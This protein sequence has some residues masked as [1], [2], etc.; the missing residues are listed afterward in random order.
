MIGLVISSSSYRR[1]RWTTFINPDLDPL[2]QSFHIRQITL[3]LGR[4]GLLGQGIGNSK[5]KLSYLPEASSDSIFAIAAE[6]L[7]LW[8][9]LIILGLFFNYWWAGYR[10][11]SQQ[12]PE[13]F[14]R[15]IAGGIWSWIVVQTSLNL[16]AVLALV[17]LTGIPLP[18]FSYG[19][20]ALVMVIW[21]TGLLLKVS[22]ENPNS[23]YR[24]HVGGAN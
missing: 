2:G 20:T 9:S 21:A 5:Q 17:P 11:V 8:G 10:I 24:Y 14:T 13:S 19:G 6:E 3:A 22:Q 12:P 16:S 15:L 23:K 4:G 18:F 1:A 7:G